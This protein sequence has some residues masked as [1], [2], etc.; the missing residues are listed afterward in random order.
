MMAGSG[1]LMILNRFAW[2]NW[3]WCGRKLNRW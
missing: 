1:V 3:T 2:I